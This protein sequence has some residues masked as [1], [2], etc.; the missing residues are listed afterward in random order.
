MD[1]TV[2]GNGSLPIPNAREEGD[3][4]VH[5]RLSLEEEC[6]I[7]QSETAEQ[8]PHPAYGMY[9][10]TDRIDKEKGEGEDAAVREENNKTNGRPDS[11]CGWMKLLI[12]TPWVNYFNNLFPRPSKLDYGLSFWNPLHYFRK[13]AGALRGSDPVPPNFVLVFLAWLGS[14]SGIWLVTSRPSPRE[15]HAHSNAKFAPV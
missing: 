11:F 1:H 12:V 2:K 3:A 10:T 13:W 7:Q 8:I 15:K 5:S 6:G 9:S 4:Q 14:F